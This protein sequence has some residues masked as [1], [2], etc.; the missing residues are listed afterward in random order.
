VATPPQCPPVIGRHS[1]I[2]VNKGFD[3]LNDVGSRRMEDNNCSGKMEVATT[4]ANILLES[5][6]SREEEDGFNSYVI[7]KY[8]HMINI[9]VQMNMGISG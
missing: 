6:K 4:A 2:S 9:C 7:F 5:Y 1:E 3:G 8:I